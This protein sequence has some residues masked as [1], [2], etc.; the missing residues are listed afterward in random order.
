MDT[1]KPLSPGIPL[2]RP[3]CA[4]GP[5][6]TQP[7]ARQQTPVSNGREKSGQ[8]IVSETIGGEEEES[9]LT[10]VGTT[11]CDR[12]LGT[13]DPRHALGECVIEVHRLFH[14]PGRL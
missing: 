10:A 2:A 14:M 5:H 1:L 3:L 8:N 11:I 9:S 6:A 12:V 7:L 4:R 13:L